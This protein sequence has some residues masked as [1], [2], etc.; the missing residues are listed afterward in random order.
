MAK[1]ST[2]ILLCIA[3]LITGAAIYVLFRTNAYISK[4]FDCV[5]FI[6]T[7]RTIAV[8]Y[9]NGFIKFYLPDFLWCFALCCG[10][11]AIYLPGRR[12]MVICALVAFSCGT[13]WELLQWGGAVSGTGDFWDILMYLSGSILSILIN[14]KGEKT[15]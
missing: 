15:K 8:G 7:L 5:D 1:R 14:I 2:N 3:A 13:L 9:T 10:M 4:W 11:Q 12:G 6:G